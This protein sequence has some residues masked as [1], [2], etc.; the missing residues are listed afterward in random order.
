M[1]GS[2][3]GTTLRALL[4]APATGLPPK[5][6]VI[7]D[8]AVSVIAERGYAGA[9]TAE[10]A[11]RAG[12]T[13]MTLFKYFP[14]KAKFLEALPG[15]VA[16]RILRPLLLASLDAFRSAEAE[17]DLRGGL[18]TV[19][20]DRIALFAGQPELFK[21]ALDLLLHQGVESRTRLLGAFTE[22][23]A[24]ADAFHERQAAQGR[25]RSA[26][27]AF[28][29]RTTLA[30]ILGYSL[31]GLLFPDGKEDGDL[32]ARLAELLVHGLASE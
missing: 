19:L 8:A 3:A 1:E 20:R 25:Y 9:T 11:K 23:L 6:R 22:V 12:V 13:E 24:Y 5:A 18:E 2:D 26:D 14:A 4:D 31:M 15:L 28:A 16:E 7:L 27:P 29:S 32:P 21:A 17:G 30:L 10:I